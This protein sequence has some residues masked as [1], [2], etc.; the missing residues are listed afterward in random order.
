M[1]SGEKNL[2]GHLTPSF[3]QGQRGR[4]SSDPFG[5][6]SSVEGGERESEA[7]LKSNE[8]SLKCFKQGSDTAKW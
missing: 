7:F 4:V 3:T 1:K 5:P 6:P 2:T 8:K